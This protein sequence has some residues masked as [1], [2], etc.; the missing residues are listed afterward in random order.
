M[1]NIDSFEQ[2][3]LREVGNMGASHAASALSGLLNRAVTI[4]VPQLDIIPIVKFPEIVGGAEEAVVAIYVT[5]SGGI[6][7]TVMLV[8]REQYAMTLAD[9]LM[10]KKSGTTKELSEMEVSAIEE[11]GNIMVSSF[12]NALADFMETEIM[13]TP[14]AF[15]LDMAGAL[16]DALIIQV[17]QKADEAIFFHTNFVIDPETIIG[18]MFLSPDEDSLEKIFEKLRAKVGM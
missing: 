2:D 14:P 4:T 9:V 12:S 3:A 17:G 5:L 13:P 18:H 6:T 16:L 1:P 11:V 7:A 15:G 10:G 8:F